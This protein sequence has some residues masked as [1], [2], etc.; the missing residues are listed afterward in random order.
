M[1]KQQKTI[2]KIQLM[3]LLFI[4][5][6]K[7]S[8]QVFLVNWQ[9]NDSP[10]PFTKGFTDKLQPT[11]LHN[12]PDPFTIGFTDKLQPRLLHYMLHGHITAQLDHFTTDF[13]DKLQLRPLHYGFHWQITA[14]T[15]SQRVSLTRSADR[16]SSHGIGV[17]SRGC[18][19][20]PI[21]VLMMP[22]GVMRRMLGPSAT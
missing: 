7:H 2:N 4:I 8:S 15:P 12:S 5:G 22:L 17:Q 3:D 16:M 19:W 18:S 20:E 6:C 9:I 21:R 14:H 1:K 13:T 10:H 11:P